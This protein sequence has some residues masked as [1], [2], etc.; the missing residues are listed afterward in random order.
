M[1]QIR[2]RFAQRENEALAQPYDGIYPESGKT[3]DLFPIRTTGVNTKPIQ[4]AAESFLRSLDDNQRDR[5][6]F[7]VD[8]EEWRRW[9]NVDN[10]IYIRQGVS[11]HEM[12]EKQRKAAWKLMDV[13]LSP[14]GVQLSK[15]IMKTDHTLWELNDEDP[16]YG[17]LLYF[18][19]MMGEPSD[20]EPWGWQID[21]HH[22]VINF[23]VL[24]DQVVFSPAF[25]GAEPVI[26][27]TGKYAG[28]T[29]FQDEQNLGVAFM[30]SLS[31]EEQAKATLSPEKKNSNN[32][33]EAFKDN[34]SIEYEGLHMKDVSAA[35]KG[36]LLDL[37]D[38]YI[39]NMNEGHAQVRLEE[40]AAHMDDTWFA[41][42]GETSEDAVFYYRIYSPVVLIEFD[43]QSPVG[44]PN[45]ER[46]ASRNHI[47]TL[48][49]TPNGNDY[50]KDLLRQHLEKHH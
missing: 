18:F 21:G 5:T 40:I 16:V 37:V 50:G 29:L 11:L 27:T 3:A 7:L 35:K 48:I 8:D 4:K 24:G 36:M 32:K 45:V 23:F 42:V 30:Q 47:H 13:S 46:R 34:V 10:G 43:H 31:M 44:V 22:L 26:T 38:R 19:T 39:S 15:D 28:N 17:E 6:V 25:L 20:T 33:A 1:A 12:T 2:D 41:W 49:R 14:Q 9:C